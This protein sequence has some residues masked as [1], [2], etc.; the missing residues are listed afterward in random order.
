MGSFEP[1][2]LLL[3]ALGVAFLL[4]AAVVNELARRQRHR[5]RGFRVRRVPWGGLPHARH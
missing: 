3:A 5:D 4:L 1:L 2:A